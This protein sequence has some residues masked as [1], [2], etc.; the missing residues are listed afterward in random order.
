[1]A[2]PG[3]RRYGT[4]VQRTRLAPL[5]ALL[6]A[7]VS[8]AAPP[9]AHAGTDPER[10]W[11]TL[12]T[13][14]FAV[15]TYDGGEALA[16]RAAGWAEAAWTELNPVFGW[17]PEERIHVVVVD[18]G[19]SAN[20][21]A[22]VMPYDAITLF[23]HPPEADGSL[24]DYDDWLKLLVYHEYAHVVH[25]D[26]AEGL[27]RVLNTVLGKSIKPNQALPRWLTEGLATWVE[28]TYTAAGRVGSSRFEM[29]LR[30]AVL[31][32][33]LLEL[34][35]LTGEPLRH[36]RGT[37]WY[38]YGS[39]LVDH[40][41]R[42]T[43]ADAIRAFVDAYGRRV[44]PFS[45][46]ITARQ[47]TGKDLAAWYAELKTALVARAH[48]TRDAL[49]AAG[50]LEGVRRTRGGE[51]KLYP[52]LSPDGRWLVYVRADGHAQAELVAAP[53]ADPSDVRPI[54]RCDGGC[55]RFA[56]TR[57][58]RELVLASGRPYRQVNWYTELVRVPF[59]PH[60]PRRA[61]RVLTRGART[62]EPSV[63][64][65]GDLVWTASSGWG[66]TWLEARDATTGALRHRW[67][68]PPWARV[69]TPVASPD[70]RTVYVSMHHAGNR[71]LYAVDLASGQASRLTEGR[72]LE[73]DLSLSP[74]G[75]WLLYS[76]DT[77]GIYDVYAREL[78]TGRTVRLT[79]VLSGAF[80]PSVSPDGQILVYTGWTAQGWELYTLPFAPDAAPL[81]ADP[82]GTELRPSA[83]EPPE[84]TIERRPYNPLPTMLPRNWI[85]T[86]FVDS[87]GFSRLGLTFGGADAS[88]RLSSAIGFEV[89]L[90]RDDFSAFASV[91]VGLWW[92][93]VTLTAGRYTWD[94]FSFFDDRFEDYRE[95]VLFSSLDVSLPLPSAHIGMFVGGT[96]TADLSRAVQ[97]APVDPSPDQF[98]SFVPREGLSTSLRL[99]WQLSDVERFAFSVSPMRGGSASAAFRLRHPAIGSTLTNYT[100]SYGLTRY[101]PM[102]WAQDHVTALRMQGGWSGGESPGTFTLGGVPD[103]NIFSDLV[104]L[105]QA[106]ATWLRGFAP[107]AYVGTAY[108]LLSTEYRLPLMRA[109]TGLETLPV[110]VRDVAGALFV[111]TGLA[112]SDPFDLDTFER[113]RVGV[114]AELRTELE[115]FFGLTTSLRLGYGYGLG[116]DGGGQLYLLMAPPP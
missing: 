80:Q 39:Y 27:P 47:T 94:R 37:S 43:G 113:L 91:G 52:R 96:F 114:G 8:S 60:Q 51:V 13:E 111:D 40:I 54:I 36:P 23:A 21:F 45:M 11:Y 107:N 67:D 87:F 42:A 97:A 75:R 100:L 1:M 14:H 63:A 12:L 69:N 2:P 106:G 101:L 112:Y 5:L 64:P 73:I 55:G 62:T 28:S 35:E 59:T 50:R 76:S 79:R 3:P 72:A 93:Q 44:I 56:F 29:I 15:H 31:E 16:R 89:D 61:G 98:T 109:R 7:L 81:V 18:D 30:T 20:G 92:P 105:T 57:D 78:A 74:D 10:Q 53:V 116:P 25:L 108:H 58:G 33:R 19:D 24:S 9:P 104:N 103:Q 22:S 90:D 4:R 68:P 49:Q 38:L 71:D 65:A 99:Y 6:L 34:D 84:I 26:N 17:T 86:Y 115:L 83:G 48:A 95:E 66:Q 85:P 102:P 70:G 88:G 110:F 82:D 32:D 77:T 46:N 41:V